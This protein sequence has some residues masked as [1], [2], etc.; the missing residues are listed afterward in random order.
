MACDSDRCAALDPGLQ[1]A[2]LIAATGP[3]RTLIT[4]VRLH[5]R[6][7]ITE[8]RQGSLY[9]GPDAAGQLF[10]AVQHCCRY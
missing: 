4:Q 1:H 7:L 2:P 8:P 3:S 10:A 5:P 6:D 9:P